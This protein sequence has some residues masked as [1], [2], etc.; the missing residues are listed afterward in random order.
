[1]ALD[2]LAYG[3]E[4]NVLL[5]LDGAELIAYD[6]QTEAPKWQVAFTDPLLSV[7]FAHPQALPTAGGGSPWREAAASHAAIV[8]DA[9]GSLHAVDLSLG[10]RLGSIGPLGKPRSVASCVSTGALAVVAGDE[11]LV[12]RSGHLVEVP[13]AGARASALAF[14]V[15][16]R[17]L[18]V[19]TEAGDVIMFSLD[20]PTVPAAPEEV[21]PPADTQVPERTFAAHGVGAVADLV[22]HPSGTWIAAGARGVFTVTAE[23]AQRLDKLPSGALRACFDATGATL[24]VQRSDRAIAVY[25]WPALSV[26]ARIEYTERPVRGIAFGPENWLGVALDGG[27]G[28]K[29]DIVTSATHRTDTA[30]GRTHRSWT[31]HVESQRKLLSDKEAEEIRRMKSPFHEPQA[32]RGN[33]NGGKVGIGAFLSLALIGLRLCAHST[34][35]SHSTYYDNAAAHATPTAITCDVACVKSRVVELESD[36]VTNT[37]LACADDVADAKKA[38]AAGRCEDALA[39]LRRIPSSAVSAGAAS[40]TPL[41]GAHR[42]LAEYG[43]EEACRNGAIRAPLAPQ[44]TQLVRF[45]R[46]AS[47]PTVEPI[48][49]QDPARGEIPRALFAAADGTVFAA[50]VTEA[51]RRRCVVYKRSTAGAWVVSHSIASPS[52]DVTIV[53]RSASDVYL[54]VGMTIAHFDG[55]SWSS[56]AMPT[57]DI[58]DGAAAAGGELFVATSMSDERRAVHRR[59]GGAWMKEATPT[60]VSFRALHGAGTSLWAVAE[61]DQ[62]H[63]VL[64][65][66]APGG[67][68]STRT[69]SGDQ[70]AS[71]AVQSFWASPSGEVFVGTSSSVLRSK[72]GGA[73][74]SE[75]PRP[76][77]VAALWGRSSTDVYALEGSGLV[78]FD[79]KSWSW[80]T[81]DLR[82]GQSLSGT[83]TDVLVLRS[84]AP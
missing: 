58:I 34:G 71:L 49:E 12:W 13:L 22:A 20:A 42:I 6:A 30:P 81:D 65:R 44:R 53:G 45:A 28:N 11:V 55:V 79:G 10:K 38:I 14:S 36:C 83:A 63:Q 39:A 31:L 62:E 2:A 61:D 40:A 72:D 21:Q 7:A 73:S 24:A 9:E 48:P 32:P 43:L 1:M 3:P 60:G 80:I 57:D 75:E 26:V 25:A 41:F 77:G 54:A 5:V 17:T 16:G 23:G 69:P 56:T 27:D 68:W 67:V 64:L 29:I 46:S 84:V 37:A 19:G 33:G 78:H 18:A 47:S 35:S 8:L 59:H 52:N 70:G 74:W 51:P 4:A 15:D 50:T 66:R 82:G 76:D